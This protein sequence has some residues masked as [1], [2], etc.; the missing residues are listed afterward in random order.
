MLKYVR[1]LPGIV[2]ARMKIIVS[3]ENDLNSNFIKY[4]DKYYIPTIEVLT[5]AREAFEKYEP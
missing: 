4:S 5:K 1:I 2:T 3:L